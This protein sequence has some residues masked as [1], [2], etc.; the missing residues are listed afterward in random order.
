MLERTIRR[1]LRWAGVLLL[2]VV[3]VPV[4]A[5]R[6]AAVVAGAL[7]PEV[8]STTGVRLEDTRFEEIRFRNPIQ[9]IELAGMLF[10]PDGDGPFPAAVLISGSGTSTRHNRWTLTL[11]D[12]LQRN[13][14]LVLVPDKRGSDRSG[15]D[16]RTASFADLATDTLAAI[17]HLADNSDVPVSSIGV[18]GMSQGGRIAPIVA[19]RS[20]DVA[21]VVNVSGGTVTLHEA[22]HYEETHNLRRVGFLPGVSNALAY[23]STWLLRNVTAADF[24][25]AVGNFDPLPYWEAIA[26][27]ALVLYG[28]HDT[29][30]PIDASVERLSSLGNPNITVNVYPGSGHALED[31]TGDPGRERSIFRKDALEEIVA[32]ILALAR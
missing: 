22:L 26:I 2:G 20:T 13:G 32:F 7:D 28:E 14:I 5:T 23:G 27:P 16:W 18:V 3:L 25:Q 10:V 9:G 6:I 21:W 8:R 24:W 30:V 1:P 17:S 19:D 29:N 31:P 12:H 11:V 4:A 15:G